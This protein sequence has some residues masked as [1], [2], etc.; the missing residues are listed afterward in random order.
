MREKVEQFLQKLRPQLNLDGGDVELIDVSAD[1]VVK[2]K[3][4]GGCCGCPFSLMALHMGLESSLKES[5]PGI[6]RVDAVRA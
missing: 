6:L 2:V 4:V 3:F 5:V 1:G